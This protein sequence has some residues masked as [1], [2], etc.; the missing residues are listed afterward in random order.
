MT[1]VSLIECEVC[2]MVT[3]SFDR[4]RILEEAESHR[5]AYPEHQL[6]L[7]VLES[8]ESRNL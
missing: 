1:D 2:G 6:Y 8:K 3:F 7:H 4:D 5:T